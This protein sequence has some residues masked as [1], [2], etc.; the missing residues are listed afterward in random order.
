MKKNHNTIYL[1]K[2]KMN[3]FEEM[4][5]SII[6]LTKTILENHVHCNQMYTKDVL[7]TIVI[8]FTQRK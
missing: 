1:L 2:E 3:V 4:T 7:K 5:D 8:Y 6:I